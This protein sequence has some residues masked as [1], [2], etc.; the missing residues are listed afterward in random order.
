MLCSSLVLH[1]TCLFMWTCYYSPLGYFATII[2]Y[3]CFFLFFLGLFQCWFTAMP[4]SPVSTYVHASFAKFT[5]YRFCFVLLC[6]GVLLE[7][8]RCNARAL[9]WP[10]PMCNSL[11]DCIVLSK[12]DLCQHNEQCHITWAYTKPTYIKPTYTKPTCRLYLYSRVYLYKSQTDGDALRGY[13]NNLLFCTRQRS[14]HDFTIGLV[15][16]YHTLYMYYS[17]SALAVV[18]SSS[19]VGFNVPPNTL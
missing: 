18:T 14:S 6:I 16:I 8:A 17:L 15:F 13:D 4:L 1:I 7:Y 2:F 3:D 5:C 9:E 19:G 10:W 11:S 12:S